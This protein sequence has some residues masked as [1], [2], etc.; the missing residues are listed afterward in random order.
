MSVLHRQSEL[1]MGLSSDS[2]ELLPSFEEILMRGSTQHQFQLLDKPLKH[3]HRMV[4]KH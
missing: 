4:L 2:H 3:F 1:L